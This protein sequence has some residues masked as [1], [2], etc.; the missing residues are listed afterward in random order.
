MENFYGYRDTIQVHRTKRNKDQ[1]GGP[2]NSDS[3][4]VHNPVKKQTPIYTSQNRTQ[5]TAYTCQQQT[6]KQEISPIATFQ[7]SSPLDCSFQLL[8][9]FPNDFIS[10]LDQDRVLYQCGE[11]QFQEISIKQEN[12]QE[13]Y[14]LNDDGFGA[15]PGCSFDSIGTSGLSGLSLHRGLDRADKIQS[16]HKLK[17]LQFKNWFI[18]IVNQVQEGNERRRNQDGDIY[19]DSQLEEIAQ[20]IRTRLRRVDISKGGAEDRFKELC[21]KIVD[22]A[23]TKDMFE[24]EEKIEQLRKQ[25]CIRIDAKTKDERVQIPRWTRDKISDQWKEK[26]VYL[27]REIYVLFHPEDIHTNHLK[28]NQIYNKYC[29]SSNEVS[30]PHNLCVNA[31]HYEKVIDESS[32]CERLRHWAQKN[33]VFIKPGMR[34]DSD[35]WDKKFQKWVKDLTKYLRNDR[36]SSPDEFLRLVENYSANLVNFKF[37]NLCLGKTEPTGQEDSSESTRRKG[38]FDPCCLLKQKTTRDYDIKIKEILRGILRYVRHEPNIAPDLDPRNLWQCSTRNRDVYCINPH[39]CNYEPNRKTNPMT[40][41]LISPP[42]LPNQNPLNPQ[43]LELPNFSIDQW[44]HLS[45]IRFYKVINGDP[46]QRIRRLHDEMQGLCET[47]KIP[48][49][50][51]KGIN[52]HLVSS[53]KVRPY[54][55]G[56]S[57]NS[58]SKFDGKW[59]LI[60]KEFEDLAACTELVRSGDDNHKQCIAKSRLQSLNNIICC[61]SY[62]ANYSRKSFILELANLSKSRQFDVEMRMTAE[63][64]ER[65]HASNIRRD[66]TDQTPR[67]L[68]Y[69]ITVRNT[70]SKEIFVSLPKPWTEG[71]QRPQSDSFSCETCRIFQRLQPKEVSKELVYSHENNI[72]LEDLVRKFYDGPCSLTVHEKEES[73]SVR[74]LLDWNKM[75]E[76]HIL[77]EKMQPLDLTN[78]NYDGLFYFTGSF[79]HLEYFL[80]QNTKTRQFIENLNQTNSKTT[81]N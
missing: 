16:E 45:F 34:Q 52:D 38:P 22:V 39:H 61:H 44:C 6:L 73:S 81:S 35:A 55:I 56:F 71:I 25:P 8:S 28:H 4:N 31:L 10:D 72:Q 11:N 17:E 14:C 67:D 24:K 5:T 80:L 63:Q 30:G 70:G 1:V 47:D 7:Q 2:H 79:D 13:N 9:S 15:D 21:D 27:A 53:I 3:W 58:K 50:L 32:F 40:D 23:N 43:C 78:S 42:T 19:S 60:N 77:Q 49:S 26:K 41:S 54:S 46:N 37:Q 18:S 68:E 57:P 76:K 64:V 12:Y 33:E 75:G 65:Y 29:S 59:S 74:V 51:P 20:A 36:H 48:S 66:V 62:R 69:S